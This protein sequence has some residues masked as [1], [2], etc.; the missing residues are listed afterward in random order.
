MVKIV[1]GSSFKLPDKDKFWGR[2]DK[3]ISWEECDTYMFS[4]VR[5]MFGEKYGKLLWRNELLCLTKLVVDDDGGVDYY[6]FVRHCE[7][8]LGCRRD[9]IHGVPSNDIS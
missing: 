5:T 6:K 9:A 4:Q 1:P 3:G 2:T 8:H 7:I